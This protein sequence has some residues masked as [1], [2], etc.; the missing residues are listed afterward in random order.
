L[1]LHSSTHSSRASATTSAVVDADA[2]AGVVFDEGV[3]RADDDDDEEEEE[4]E[5]G[6][7]GAGNEATEEPEE[8]GSFHEDSPVA[9]LRQYL[10]WCFVLHTSDQLDCAASSATGFACLVFSAVGL[11]LVSFASLDEPWAGADSAARGSFHEDSPVTLLRQKALLC[12]LLNNSVH[13][14]LEDGDFGAG[15][16]GAGAGAG[17]GE[18]AREEEL[19]LAA[20]PARTCGG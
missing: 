17:A 5:E 15:D 3:A 14:A 11:G 1:S 8:V 6:V 9:L 7:A 20:G 19:F 2:D 16:F 10:L 4:D 18:A 13:S 12:F